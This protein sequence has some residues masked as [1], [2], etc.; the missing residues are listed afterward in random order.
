[1]SA[2]N[3]FSKKSLCMLN[4]QRIKY[5]HNGYY[6]PNRLGLIH[7]NGFVMKRYFASR[8][9][10]Q[11]KFYHFAVPTLLIIGG[12]IYIVGSRVRWEELMDNNPLPEKPK[13]TNGEHE[14]NG[15]IPS[16][17]ENHNEVDPHIH[18]LRIRVDRAQVLSD[19]YDIFGKCD[20]FVEIEYDGKKKKT[21]AVKNSVNPRWNQLIRFNKAKKGK[22]LKIKIY[23]WDG[24]ST[25]DFVGYADLTKEELPTKYNQAKQLEIK[26]RDGSG[27]ETATLY[28]NMEFTKLNRI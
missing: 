20:A 8:K 24:I 14:E 10:P 11:L 12:S 18:Y 1:M 5:H 22:K 16:T 17:A 21:K 15:N 27:N 6:R 26:I 3:R 2:I 7:P 4:I 13:A 19:D 28:L 9:Q 23:D 25:H